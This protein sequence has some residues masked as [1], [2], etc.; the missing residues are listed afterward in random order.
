MRLVDQFADEPLATAPSVIGP[1]TI[2]WVER[3]ARVV[4]GS[5]VPAAALAAFAYFGG[6]S[7]DAAMFFVGGPL[8]ALYVITRIEAGTLPPPS[9]KDRAELERWKRPSLVWGLRH[10]IVAT[11]A[12]H[13]F[14]AL[15][16]SVAITRLSG[17][18]V[19][20]MLV[21]LVIATGVLGVVFVFLGGFCVWLH[22]GHRTFREWIRAA[23]AEVRQEGTVDSRGRGGVESQGRGGTVNVPRGTEDV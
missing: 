2:Q 13:W 3:D 6:L 7:G 4:L 20:I 15:V 22:V 23:S 19:S 16:V 8:V 17:I 1:R 11:F 5:V 9:D 12:L 18:D 14:L 10:L 21:R